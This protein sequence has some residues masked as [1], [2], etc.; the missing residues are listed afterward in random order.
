MKVAVQH[1]NA[2]TNWAML[3]ELIARQDNDWRRN[4]T[5]MQNVKSSAQ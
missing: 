2:N 5:W 1:R 3:A 4:V